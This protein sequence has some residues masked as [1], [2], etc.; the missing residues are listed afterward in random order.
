MAGLREEKC[1]K[2]VQRPVV[3]GSPRG[4]LEGH[5]GV[6]KGEPGCQPLESAPSEFPTSPVRGHGRQSLRQPRGASVL[7]HQAKPLNPP[8]SV[9]APATGGVNS[10]PLGV[11]GTALCVP[12]A[13]TG[14]PSEN[15]LLISSCGA[16]G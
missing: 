2:D 8:S 9:S 16:R 14:K 5:L 4:Y 10:V 3:R 7:D 6:W 15:V 12:Q 13:W 1:R 11:L